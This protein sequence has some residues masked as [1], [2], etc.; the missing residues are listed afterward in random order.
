M[1]NL[2]PMPI[3]EFFDN[4]G[5]PLSG[6]KLYAYLTG[7][8][9]ATPTYTDAA[10]LTANTNPVVLNARGEASVWLDPAITYKFILR[11]SLGAQL[12]SVDGVTTNASLADVRSLIGG[13]LTKS[14][15]GGSNVTLTA[16]E[17][18]KGILV[19]TGALTANI[20]VILPAS[21]TR[22]WVVRNNTTGAFTLTVKT[23]A[24]TGVAV[25]QT[26]SNSLYSD[27]TNISQVVTELVDVLLSGN[28]T[29]GSGTGNSH[30]V[31]GAVVVTNGLNVSS[32][33]LTAPTEVL[34][35]AGTASSNTLGIVSVGNGLFAPAANAIGV[36]TAGVERQRIAA[37]GS[38]STVIPGGSTLYPDFGARAWVNFNG[39]NGV[40][41]AGG[42]VSS[43]TRNGASDYTANFATAM[44]DANYA[45]NTSSY[46]LS[47][48]F[49]QYRTGL[50]TNAINTSSFRFSN[51]AGDSGGGLID[52]PYIFLLIFR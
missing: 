41:R 37:D 1:A 23:A 44:S 32:G 30:T 17:A 18:A 2:M 33:V 25:T 45:A 36:S 49:G 19:F 26:E 15:A 21:P 27:G 51:P 42:N 7:T 35:S 12:W 4:N 8:S 13:V 20:S 6:G 11:T 3:M 16:S 47:N 52:N 46:S 9:T 39:F 24:G 28:T 48:A 22:S 14:V 29:L 34:S 10:G 50:G 5:N 38:F 43:V 40:V 31:N